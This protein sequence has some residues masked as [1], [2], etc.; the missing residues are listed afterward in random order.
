MKKVALYTDLEGKLI[1]RAHPL[2][3]KAVLHH[4]TKKAIEKGMIVNGKKTSLLRITAASSYEAHASIRDAQGNL[5][6]ST[7]SAKYL[8]VTIDSN[9]SMTS[10]VEN[11]RKKIRARSWTLSTLR[12]N[13]FTDEEL[14]KVY[15]SHIRPIAEYAAQAWGP[16]IN[17]D[18]AD[19][20][21]K[22]QNQALKNIFG[23]GLSIEKM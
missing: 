3:A 17:Q 14:V 23:L 20:I 13:G 19:S 6:N 21:E 11:V 5:V 2:Q 18:Q 7:G 1:K 22:Q 10:H 15:C 8:G 4:I 16:M 12:R 9:C